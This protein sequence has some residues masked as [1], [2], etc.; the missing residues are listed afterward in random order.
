[1]KYLNEDEYAISVKA[2]MV[3]YGTWY[4]NCGNTIRASE[5]KVNG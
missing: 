2:K 3:N 5:Q 1:M 4:F